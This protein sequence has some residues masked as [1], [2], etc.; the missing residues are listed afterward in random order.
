[1]E[2]STCFRNPIILACLS[3]VSAYLYYSWR[4]KKELERDPSLGA[5][6]IPYVKLGL[7]ALAAFIL[8]TFLEKKLKYRVV[9]MSESNIH[10]PIMNL[11]RDIVNRFPNQDI[12]LDFGGF[13]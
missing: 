9:K 8:G 12:F 10:T 2:C 7:V 11:T 6:E 13:M 3:G 4:H 5:F 1:M